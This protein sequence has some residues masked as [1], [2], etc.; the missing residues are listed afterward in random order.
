MLGQ[1]PP[2]REDRDKRRRELQALMLATSRG[3]VPV[4]INPEAATLQNELDTE[5]GGGFGNWLKIIATPLAK[6]AGKTNCSTCEARRIATNAY[7]KLKKKYGQVEALRI[8]KELWADS[9]SKT[10][11]EVL[12]SLKK[13]LH[14]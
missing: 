14:D 6:L 4:H 12:I 1:Q 5:L 3:E 7:A 2:K 10:G 8:I 11:D 13:Y 9:M